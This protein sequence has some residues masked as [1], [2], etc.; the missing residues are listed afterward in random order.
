MEWRPPLHLVVVAIQKGAFGSPSATVTNFIFLYKFTYKHA[1]GT[2]VYLC[3]V[4]LDAILNSC[5]LSSFL[6]LSNTASCI[7]CVTGIPTND[8]SELMDWIFA[9]PEI[10]SV[11]NNPVLLPLL[12]DTYRNCPVF[13]LLFLALIVLIRISV[14][15][16]DRM[17]SQSIKTESFFFSS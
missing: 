12:S 9:L 7:Q 4:L 2:C 10:N 8:P 17:T 13:F 5:F 16:S 3:Y 6:R 11:F 14:H 15:S 1:R